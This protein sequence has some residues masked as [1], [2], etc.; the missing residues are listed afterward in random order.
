MGR[1]GAEKNARDDTRKKNFIR[2]K[3]KKKDDTRVGDAKTTCKWIERRI[4]SEAD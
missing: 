1:V 3:G 4:D 2:H